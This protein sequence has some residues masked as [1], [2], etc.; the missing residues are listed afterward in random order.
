MEVSGFI[1]ITL[2]KI[3]FRTERNYDSTVPLYV[4]NVIGEQ[5]NCGAKCSR[6]SDVRRF[7]KDLNRYFNKS[8]KSGINLFVKML[9]DAYPGEKY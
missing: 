1:L 6:W 4:R 3:V 8:E 7:F 9:H 5:E 2:L